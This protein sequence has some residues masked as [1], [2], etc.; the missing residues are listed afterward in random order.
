MLRAQGA[1]APATAHLLA[2]RLQAVFLFQQQV[3]ALAAVRGAYL[4]QIAIQLHHTAPGFRTV[5]LFPHPGGRRLHIAGRHAQAFQLADHPSQYHV[6]L[7]QGG[8]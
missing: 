6:S 8:H 7:A 5:K 1:E 2:A 3:A 4:F